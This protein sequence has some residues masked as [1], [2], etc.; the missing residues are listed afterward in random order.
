MTAGIYGIFDSETNECLYVG[1]SKD[2]ENRW[3]RGHLPALRSNRHKR[4]DFNIWFQDFG[5]DRLRFTILE[6]CENSESVKN[7]LEIYYFNKLKPRFYGKRPSINETWEMTA[8]TIDK[9]KRTHA[10]KWDG[11]RL[12]DQKRICII[13]NKSFYNRKRSVVTCSVSCGSRKVN[14]NKGTENIT[15][16]N[17]EE[18]YFGQKLTLKEIGEIFS[19]SHV[20]VY[21][22]MDKFEI[23]R[24]KLGRTKRT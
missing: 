9:L 12:L 21:N 3:S 19:I 20:S 4:D 14:G 8:S 22:L 11:I 17:L 1:Q 5:E 16:K 2:C 7:K 6:S 24:R 18:L 13:C 10:S 23:P 15:K